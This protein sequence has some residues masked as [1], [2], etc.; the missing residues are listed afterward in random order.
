MDRATLI[1][2]ID[3]GPVRVHMNDGASYDIPDHKSVL[4]D[5]SIAYVLH[6]RT[7]GT[8]GAVWLSLVCMT[9]VE[10]IEIAA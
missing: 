9:K 10:R 6:R 5:S 8:L 3:D 4:V 7:D 2:A 1:N